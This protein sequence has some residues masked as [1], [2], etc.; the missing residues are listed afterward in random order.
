MNARVFSDEERAA[1]SEKRPSATIAGAGELGSGDYGRVRVLGAGDVNGDVRAER[2]GVYGAASLHGDATVAYVKAFGA[3]TVQGNVRA[4]S[5]RTRGASDI[6]GIV[7]VE[8]L[9]TLGAFE[10]GSVEA[11]TF[12]ARGAIDIHGLLSGDVVEL[13]LG[14]DGDSRVREIGGE[15]VEVWKGGFGKRSRFLKALQW[16]TSPVRQGRLRAESI[17][18]DDVTL[19]HTA[20][21]VVRGRRIEIRSGCSIGT[22][23][24]SE[25]LT[26]HPKA[27][28]GTRT[29]L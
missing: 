26:V 14:G 12:L 7:H 1:L 4:Q 16:M 23:E 19:E 17:E 5:Y 8:E 20:A 11:G 9:H 27:H 24:Y 10:A 13:H 2:L 22:V 18:A 6:G 3:I 15:R 25:S 21:Q 29:R 28:V